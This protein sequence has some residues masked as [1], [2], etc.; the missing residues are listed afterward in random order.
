LGIQQTSYG[1][2]NF[3]WGDNGTFKAFL[4]TYP[5]KKEGL[6]YFANSENGLDIARDILKLFFNSDQPALDWLEYDSVHAPR[7]QLYLHGLTMPV[8]DAIAPYLLPNKKIDT[9][10]LRE[11]QIVDVAN[12][13]TELGYYDKALALAE[14]NLS[15]YPSSAATYRSLGETYMRMGNATK[16][17]A[18]WKQAYALDKQYDYP[19]TLANR[20]SNIPDTTDTTKKK[21]TLR[22]SDYI[23]AHFVT[24]AG[25]FNNWNNAIQPMHWINGAWETTIQVSPGIY[26]YKFVVDGVWLTDPKNPNMNKD[27][28]D[29]ILEVN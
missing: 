8:E 18:A 24:V 10:L 28:F 21:I 9:T 1:R 27:S 14:M 2:A 3:Q 22:L 19:Q 6:V 29:S 7:L 20:L 15:N 5:E 16:S 23:N 4:I 12:R 11:Q 26:R 17:A 13:Y 25:S